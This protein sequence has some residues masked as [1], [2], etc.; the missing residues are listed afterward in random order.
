MKLVESA[1][2]GEEPARGNPI[3]GMLGYDDYAEE[4]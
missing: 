3:S 2:S 1:A 4:A